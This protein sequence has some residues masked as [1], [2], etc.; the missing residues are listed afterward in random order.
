MR[1]E[2]KELRTIT[3]LWLGSEILSPERVGGKAATLSRLL[4]AGFRVPVGFIVIDDEMR[5]IVAAFQLPGPV[6]KAFVYLI[7]HTASKAAVVRSSASVEDSKL[8]SYAGMF[9]TVLNVRSEDELLGALVTCYQGSDAVRV[10]AYRSVTNEPMDR[11]GVSALVQSMVAPAVSGV[12]F[13]SHPISGNSS[14]MVVEATF[15]FGQ[16]LVSGR[17]TPD[18]YVVAKDTRELVRREVGS[19]KVKEELRDGV[20]SEQ[21]TTAEERLTACLEAE[22]LT[23]VVDLGIRVESYLNCPQD[24]EWCIDMQEDLWLLQARPITKPLNY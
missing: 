7:S 2:T 12:T 5:S 10:R 15:G 16:T 4:I 22:Q 13:T 8:R 9:R 17:V 24:I 6:G 3:P 11:V 14:E 20:L 21:A 23:K 19:K 18:T 1:P